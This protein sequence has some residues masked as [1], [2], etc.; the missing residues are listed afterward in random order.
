MAELPA[1]QAALFWASS[2]SVRTQIA[3]AMRAQGAQEIIAFESLPDTF[4]PGWHRVP[5]SRVARYALDEP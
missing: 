3:H 1:S 2:D 5:N 4:P